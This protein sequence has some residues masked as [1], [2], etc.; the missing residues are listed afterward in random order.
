MTDL[1]APCPNCDGTAIDGH[2]DDCGWGFMACPDCGHRV[3]YDQHGNRECEN[4]GRPM[5]D[6]EWYGEL[7]CGHAQN[8][9][10]P[11]ERDLITNEQRGF[12]GV[13]GAESVWV[14][15]P[16]DPASL[17]EIREVPS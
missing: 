4:C 17:Q 3:G 5:S 11:F 10:E 16:G 7:P 6:A 13:C 14:W 1:Q 12:C 2:C 8:K 15:A 9:W